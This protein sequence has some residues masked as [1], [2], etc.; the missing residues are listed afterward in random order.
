M[1][2]SKNTFDKSVKLF[3]YSIFIV[4]SRIILV[5]LFFTGTYYIIPCHSELCVE[6][7]YAFPTT[8]LI[9]A[10][11]LFPLGNFYFVS[12][13]YKEFPS[14][15]WQY[16]TIGFVVWIFLIQATV[17]LFYHVIFNVGSDLKTPIS[18][19]FAFTPIEFVITSAIAWVYSHKKLNINLYD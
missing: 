14:K 3:F 19:L 1:K 2:I 4:L 12:K 9:F 13:Y 7:L 15:T 11:I 17:Y 5:V 18:L 16:Q 6:K 10:F 8:I